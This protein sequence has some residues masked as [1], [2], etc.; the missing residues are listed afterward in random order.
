MYDAAPHMRPRALAAGLG[1]AL[2]T[3]IHF[4][5]HK[6]PR[7]NAALSQIWSSCN[8]RAPGPATLM[9]TSDT[10]WRDYGRWPAARITCWSWKHRRLL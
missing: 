2:C 9:G 3:C 5:L 8:P 4:C 1:E 7:K 10:G 6:C